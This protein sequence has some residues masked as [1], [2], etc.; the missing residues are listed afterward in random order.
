[1]VILSS[2]IF[3]EINLDKHIK[4]TGILTT[5]TRNRRIPSNAI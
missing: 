5:F 1:M 2:N 4:C 3:I